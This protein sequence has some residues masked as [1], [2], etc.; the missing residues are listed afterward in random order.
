MVD[1]LSDFVGSNSKIQQ[2]QR[3]LND[4][5]AYFGPK[6]L[7]DQTSPIYP[8][9][10]TAYYDPTI[11]TKQERIKYLGETIEKLTYDL[12][13][14]FRPD[15]VKTDKVKVGVQ[16]FVNKNK[17]ETNNFI[18]D[19]YWYKVNNSTN[20]TILQ[21]KKEELNKPKKAYIN[22]ATDEIPSN[23]K[24]DARKQAAKRR[25]VKIQTR[26]RAR[27]PNSQQTYERN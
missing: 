15:E 18:G 11:D 8:K 27:F 23:L 16:N 25:N 20:V 6:Y 3:E 5:N 2:L 7:K 4:L 14:P 19:S 26:Q 9:D 10:A 22:N 24:F 1:D 13:H 17:E 12:T 21:S